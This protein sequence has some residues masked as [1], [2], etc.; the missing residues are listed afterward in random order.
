MARRLPD[1][2]MAD[3][4][5]YE[6][7]IQEEEEEEEEEDIVLDDELTELVEEAALHRGTTSR[8]ARSGAE[9]ATRST[10]I[11]VPLSTLARLL[12]ITGA[13]IEDEEDEDE[14]DDYYAQPTISPKPSWTEPYKEPQEAGVRLLISGEYGRV[15]PKIK[16]RLHQRRNV[17]RMLEDRRMKLRPSPKE[18]YTQELVPSS[19]GVAVASYEA[20]IYC[21]QYSADSSFYYTCCQGS[22]TRLNISVLH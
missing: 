8:Q 11:Q 5:L 10:R 4:D 22:S 19:N 18:A 6:L 14:E 21:G 12:G 3:D 16:S 17:S 20:N 13:G 9:D 7:T 2:D 1:M 15:G